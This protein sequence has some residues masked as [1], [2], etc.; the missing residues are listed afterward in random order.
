MNL[1]TLL[2]WLIQLQKKEHFLLK[3]RYRQP[4][5]C[6]HA[7]QATDEWPATSAIGEHCRVHEQDYFISH[8]GDWLL[9]FSYLG[10]HLQFP[11]VQPVNV[12]E[13]K[14][15]HSESKEP[16]FAATLYLSPGPCIYSLQNQRNIAGTDKING[17][18]YES[19]IWNRLLSDCKF[20]PR[21]W[22]AAT[23]PWC[24][25]VFSNIYALKCSLTGQSMQLWLPS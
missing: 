5:P 13:L 18:H 21:L 15:I 22:P 17:K 19:N 1:C 9:Y 25:C 3:S 11:N 16:C 7:L 2:N 8:Q 23:Y 10:M 24:H 14:D 20:F 4:C 6:M 12:S